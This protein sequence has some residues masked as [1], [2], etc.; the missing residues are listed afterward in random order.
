MP[1]VYTFSRFCQYNREKVSFLPIFH[2]YIFL[3]Y[4]EFPRPLDLPKIPFV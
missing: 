2:G 1:K 3:F 4:P